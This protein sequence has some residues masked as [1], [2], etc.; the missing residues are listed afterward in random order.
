MKTATFLSVSSIA[1]AA[2]LSTPAIAQT[3]AA[4]PDARPDATA[5]Q[6]DIVVTG[7]RASLSNAAALKRDNAAI[8]DA[9]SA[10][11][12]G[13]FPDQN[14]ADSLQ[15]VTGVQITR[16]LGEGS[17]ISVRGLSPDFTRI[18][19]NG[20]TITSTGG[21]SFDFSSLTSD[22]VSAVEVY[23]TPTADMIEGGLSATVNVATAKPL[24]YGKDRYLLA[25][26]G[27]YEPNA[28]KVG[29]HVTAYVSKMLGD[30]VG[31]YVG[32]DYQK[33]YYQIYN[34]QGYGLETAC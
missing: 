25:V 8:V 22:F 14:L 28:K 15:R 6:S 20:R 24:D 4:A 18:Q 1:M 32:A 9:I 23:K 12:I 11:D 26:E 7:I 31:I 13:R 3:A 17:Q 34:Q 29:P 5:A 33:R 16:S 27:I 19:Y 30:D 10:E 2:L 21:R